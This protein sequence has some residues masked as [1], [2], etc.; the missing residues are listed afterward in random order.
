MKKRKKVDPE[1]LKD[2]FEE[3]SKSHDT[4]QKN[5]VSERKTY[6]YRCPQCQKTLY[7]RKEAC[8]HCKYQGYIPMSSE[9]IKKIRIVLFIIILIIALIV[10]ISMRR[11]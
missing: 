10:F 11:V 7:N 3:T 4:E 2:F 5:N 8:P 6:I 9:E 1:K